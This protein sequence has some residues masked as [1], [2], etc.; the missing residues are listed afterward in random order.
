MGFPQSDQVVRFW[1]ESQVIAALIDAAKRRTIGIHA[2]ASVHDLCS[3]R[4]G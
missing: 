4:R 2:V 3:A 1:M